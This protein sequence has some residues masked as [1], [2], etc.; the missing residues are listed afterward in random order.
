MRYIAI[1]KAFPHHLNTFDDVP[2]NYNAGPLL[3]ITT[4]STSLSYYANTINYTAQ[5]EASGCPYTTF[6]PPLSNNKIVI[7]LTSFYTQV[8]VNTTSMFAVETIA[9]T[10]ETYLINV[11]DISN[12]ITKLH[13]SMVIFDQADIASTYAYY[14]ELGQIK[15]GSTGG[16]LAIESSALEK[17]FIA[18]FVSF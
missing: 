16:L 17:N 12:M 18:G 13:F 6:T 2:V 11:T 8:T 7:F 9:V 5:A 10:N 4:G 1:D 14:L 3:N 15:F